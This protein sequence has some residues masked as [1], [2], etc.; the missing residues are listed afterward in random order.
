MFGSQIII[1]EK[2]SRLNIRMVNLAYNRNI[3]I[4]NNTD[5]HD[6]YASYQILSSENT[7]IHKYIAKKQ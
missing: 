5:N 4:Q 7:F 6:T 3:D 2:Q 1:P